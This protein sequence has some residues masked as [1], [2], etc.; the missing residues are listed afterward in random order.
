MEKEKIGKY[1]RKKR[2]EKGMTQQQL[3]EKIQVTEKAVSR[4]ET[5]RGVPD[6]SLLEPLAE[7]LHVS[8]TELLNGEERV[9]EEAM[10]DTK[11]H[12]ADIDITNVI[13]YVQENRKE[14]YN[15]GFKIGIGCLVV[16]LVLFLLYLREAYRFQGNYFGT[17]IRMTVISGIFLLGEMVLERCYLVKLEE[18]RKRKKA[19]LAVL[20]I[21]YAVMLM[22]LTFL[23]RTQTVT[24]YNIV[25][26]RTI[27]TVLLSGNVYAIVINIFGNFFIFMPL[28]F[29]LIE[30]FE[31]R[32][33]KQNFL[34]CFTI[35]FVIE[36]VQYIFK[37]GMLDVDD[38]LL[39][40]AGMM[41]FYYFYGKY[42][43]KNKKRGM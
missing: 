40:V 8:V 18:R 37:V 3:A 1:I 43:G 36:I 19:V 2:I 35:T 7:E 28:Q 24:D 14:K 42:R 13:E 5:G 4:W 11:A 12:M 31:I 27:G 15:I 39:C 29:F 33:I 21:Y 6:I 25:P 32:K 34:V 17:M 22:N 16:S 10:H 26:F 23:E 38:I 30:L 20:F 9:Q 41:S